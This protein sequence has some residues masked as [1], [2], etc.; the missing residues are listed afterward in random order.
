VGI[1]RGTQVEEASRQLVDFILGKRF[2]E[3]IPLKMFVYPA[4]ETAQLPEVFV[5]HSHVSDAPA[6][7]EPDRIAA[8]R[9][10]WIQAWTEEVL[11]R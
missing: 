5:E 7:M 10:D 4:N 6:Q 9:E 2:Q 11:N 1:L 3:D 8:N